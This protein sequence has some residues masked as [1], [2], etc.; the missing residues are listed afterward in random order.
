MAFY[1]IEPE[2]LPFEVLYYGYKDFLP[3]CSCHLD[4]DPMT[5]MY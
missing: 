5:F 4:L 1:F 2:L 3:F